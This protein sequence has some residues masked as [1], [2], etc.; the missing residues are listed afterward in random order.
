M[1]TLTGMPNARKTGIAQFMGSRIGTVRP[2]VRGR[3][4]GRPRSSYHRTARPAID[5]GTTMPLELVHTG[6]RIRGF[7]DTSTAADGTVI[8]R[9][10]I[11]HPGAVVI[12]PVVDEGHIC[13]LR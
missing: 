2:K 10:V 8:R 3:I 9:D 6:R 7:G 11:K 1:W 13:L 5:R 12:L 4:V